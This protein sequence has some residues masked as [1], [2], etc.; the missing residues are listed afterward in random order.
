MDIGRGTQN[1]PRRLVRRTRDRMLAGIAAGLGDYFG[2]DPVAVRLLWVVAGF[3][4][5]PLAVLAYIVF[6]YVMP[7][8]DPVD[9]TRT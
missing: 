8:E 9:L 1:E 2:V 7:R 6:W 3:V 4:T 5:G